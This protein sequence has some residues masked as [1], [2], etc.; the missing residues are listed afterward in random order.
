[1]LQMME[2]RLSLVDVEE[3]SSQVECQKEELESNKKRK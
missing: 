1:M 2:A 3:R